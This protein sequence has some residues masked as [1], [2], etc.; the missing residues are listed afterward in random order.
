MKLSALRFCSVALLVVLQGCTQFPAGT[1]PAGAGIE[2]LAYRFRMDFNAA[3]N[4][5]TGWAAATNAVPA[6][7]HDEPF[8]LRVQV[9]AA[10]MPPEGHVL[11]LQYRSRR[12]PWHAVGVA[13]FPYPSL[14]SPLVSVTS[15]SAYAQGDETERL[16]GAAD[17]DWDEGAGLNSVATTPVW[18]GGAD[19][20]EWEWPLVVRRY[21]DGPT[22]SEDGSNVELRVVDGLG[23]PLA[24]AGAIALQLATRPGHLGGTFIE[25]PGRLG[26]YQTAAGHLYFFMEPAETDNRFMA[27]LSTDYGRSWREVDG[28]ARPQADDL[29]GVASV[30]VGSTIHLIHQVT[31]EVFHHAFV[32]DDAGVPA[33]WL[34]NSQSIATPEEPATQYADVAARSDGSL[35]TLYGGSR[36]LFLQV[37]SPQGSWGEPIEIDSAI[38]PELSGPVLATGD[39]DVITLA[40][41]GRD[42]SGFIRHLFP[43]GA[44][45][46]RELLSTR[47]GSS[48]AENGAILPLV[49]VPGTGSTVVLYRETDGLL[50]ERR[51]AR[52][53]ELSAPVRVSNLPVVTDAVDSEQ[54]GADLILHG[55]TLH[56]LFIEAASRSIYH[57][58]SAQPGR[59]SVP[60]PVVEGI[61]AAWLRGSVHRDEAG[62]AVYGFVYDGGSRGGSGFNRYLTLP[63]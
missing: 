2:L 53:G 36:R 38:E 56:L 28:A 9:R 61:D 20:V 48:D 37:R 8:R 52:T 5:D 51:L 26:P 21:S 60:R 31:R 18:R 45:S 13:N 42:G 59:W 7:Y 49:A 16:L 35:V 3:L 46:A 30:Q 40:Y 55:S 4:A 22:F 6:L 34:I 57:A 63:L 10:T 12:G 39:D 47:L 19:A 58:S 41:T 50:Y 62:N 27:M 44:L 29:E 32:L 24:G 54:V 15:T 25:T 14:A 33:H 17:L 43:D 1:G 11:G 23:Q